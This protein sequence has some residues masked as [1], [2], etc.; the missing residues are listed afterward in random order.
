MFRKIVSQLSFSPALIGQLGFYAKRLRQE[1][2][3]RRMGLV[4]VALALVV[5][6]LVIFQPPQPANAANDT[7]MV[8]GGLGLGSNRS[9]DNFMRSYNANTLKLRDAMDHVGITKE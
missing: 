5:Q 6:S 7:D 2:S 8:R 3:T 1:Q 4:F 9:F